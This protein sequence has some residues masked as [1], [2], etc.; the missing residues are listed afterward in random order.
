M[1]HYVIFDSCYNVFT[2]DDF[3]DAGFYI[4]GG[5]IDRDFNINNAIKEGDC[6]MITTSMERAFAYADEKNRGL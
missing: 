6:V 4:G 2:E 1:K 5:T 3:D